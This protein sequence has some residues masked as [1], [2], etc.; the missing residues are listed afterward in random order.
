MEAAA[1]ARGDGKAAGGI[2]PVAVQVAHVG[3]EGAALAA[4]DVRVVVWVAYA[5]EVGVFVDCCAVGEG[6]WTLRR[7]V[8]GGEVRGG[9]E[10]FGVLGVRMVK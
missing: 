3:A 10:C 9:S 6:L 8:L 7:F 1:V 2:V 4:G 5:E